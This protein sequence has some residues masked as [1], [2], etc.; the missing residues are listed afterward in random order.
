VYYI[1]LLSFAFS[2]RR[3]AEAAQKDNILLCLS[4]QGERKI[5][6]LTQQGVLR[7]GSSVCGG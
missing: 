6:Y 3:Y 4:Q 7:A 5:H 1:R 2:C